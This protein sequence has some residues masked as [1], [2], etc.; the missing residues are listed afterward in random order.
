MGESLD[1]DLDGHHP[2]ELIVD[3]AVALGHRVGG[4]EHVGEG[5][6]EDLAGGGDRCAGG[7]AVVEK[8]LQSVGQDVGGDPDV[9]PD[10]AEA[11]PPES[12]LTDHEEGPPLAHYR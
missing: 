1:G 10:L 4:I 2:G 9:A 11:A 3:E 5:V 12:Q 8:G 6:V 7:Q